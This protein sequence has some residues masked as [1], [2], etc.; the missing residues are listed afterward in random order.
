MN[1]E[2]API[3]DFFVDAARLGALYEEGVVAGLQSMES[4][5]LLIGSGRWPSVIVLSWQA[6]E[7][8]LRDKYS[9]DQKAWQLQEYFK[10]DSIDL[11]DG[12][13]E[14]AVLLRELRNSIIHEGYSPKFDKDS[15]EHFFLSALPYF[16]LLMKD[17][18]GQGMHSTLSAREDTKWFSEL[19]KDTSKVVETKLDKDVE[20]GFSTFFLQKSLMR[21][22]QMGVRVS[23]GF[24]PWTYEQ[25]Y[26]FERN[27]DAEYEAMI[28]AKRIL[29]RELEPVFHEPIS[30]HQTL[31][32][33]C[34]EDSLVV[35][36]EISEVDN[37][38]WQLE[39]VS[40]CG[41]WR[42][43]YTLKDSELI[44]V[45]IT[46]KLKESDINRLESENS[47]TFADEYRSP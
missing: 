5:F 19:I 1:S 37:N 28:H 25:D 42:C 4:A 43:C 26:L 2:S 6:C 27:Q 33:V 7:L 34:H 36:P 32:P 39:G 21:I 17:R 24:S 29:A 11:T 15:I 16:S 47:F 45:F 18:I 40:S 46:S 3:F 31:C 9:G 30:I 23:D 41:C 12:L 10:E 14:R 35:A 38:S 22:V 20:L 13:N 8:L 44:E